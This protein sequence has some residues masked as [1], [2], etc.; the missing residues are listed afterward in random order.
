MD[1]VSQFAKRCN[2]SRSTVLY[3]ESIGLLQPAVRT[4]ANYRLYGQRELR[5]LEQIRLYRS[6]GVSIDEIRAILG[7]PRTKLSSVLKRRLNQLDN[8][9]EALQEHQRMILKL[10]RMN[11]ILRRKKAMTKDKWV[12]IMKE[13]GFS[14]DDMHRWHRQFE[15]SAPA[16][17]EEFLKFLN[18]SAPEITRIREW[19]R[20]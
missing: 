13:S 10:L 2:L 4:G 1:T 7:A 11:T 9:I 8:E 3:Y 12:T 17:H 18:I 15:K 19:S 20:K 16:D 5:A 14:E 6:V